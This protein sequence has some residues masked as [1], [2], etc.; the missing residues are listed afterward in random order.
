MPRGRSVTIAT[1]PGHRAKVSSL[2][3]LE[4]KVRRNTKQL[5]SKEL[6][7]IRIDMD[8]TPDTTAVVQHVT[9]IAQGDDVTQRHGRKIHAEHI[10]IRGS[11]NKVAASAFTTVRFILF[12]DN[13]GSTT[14]PTIADL[15][16]DENDMFENKHRLIN[17][18]PMKRF[19]ILWD[20]YINLNET[21]DGQL[22][23]AYF[24]FSKKLNFDVLFTGTAQSS[25]GKNS[26]WF[27]SNSNE[28]TNVPSCKGDIV[29]KYSDL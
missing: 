23:N 20:K 24:Q 10:S 1:G 21:F 15:F 16:V 29:F 12:R 14:P 2:R 26:L 3:K 18:M 11:I 8:T 6:G 13:L 5:G 22:T 7:R 28:A 17:E 27:I 9:A 4:V 19:T 25:E